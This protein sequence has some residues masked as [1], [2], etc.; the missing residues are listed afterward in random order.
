MDTIKHNPSHDLRK[1]LDSCFA[2]RCVTFILALFASGAICHA[3]AEPALEKEK[4]GTMVRMFCVRGLSEKQQKAILATK[5]EDGKWNEYGEVSFRTSFVTELLAVPFGVT[6]LLKKNGNEMVSIGSF[7]IPPGLKRAIL[8]ML[9]DTEK[10]IY[11]IQVIDPAKA[12]FKKGKA[13]IVNYGNLQAAVQLGKDAILVAP[14]KQAVHSISANEDGMY[15]MLIGHM[16]KNKKLVPCFDRYVSSN[17]NTRKLILLFPDPVLGLSSK[18][19]SEFG[20]FE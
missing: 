12:G 9:P 2:T 17:P 1:T 3:Q 20:P 10:K 16:D 11:R 15:R 7:S 8:V 13:L 19:F 6:H 18:S 4:E 5:T 14:G